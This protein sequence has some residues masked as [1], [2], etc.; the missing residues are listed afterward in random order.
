[1]AYN[2]NIKLSVYILLSNLLTA[3]ASQL[4]LLLNRIEPKI[5]NFSEIIQTNESRCTVSGASVLIPFKG[6]HMKTSQQRNKTYRT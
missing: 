2:Y 3:G 1:M 4:L 5:R 6:Q